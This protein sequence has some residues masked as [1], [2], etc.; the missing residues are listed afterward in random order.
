VDQ[1]LRG[2]AI[3]EAMETARREAL[4]ALRASNH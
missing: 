2:P 1:G 3:G 4:E